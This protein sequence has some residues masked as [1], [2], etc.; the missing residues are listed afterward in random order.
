MSYI[1]ILHVG[2]VPSNSMWLAEVPKS[3]CKIHTQRLTWQSKITIFNGQID[4]I[5]LQMVDVPLIIL[6]FGGSTYLFW[7]AK[8]VARRS[9]CAIAQ[10]ISHYGGGHCWG[11]RWIHWDVLLD[12]SKWL[13]TLGNTVD[14]RNP[15]PPGMYKTL[16][17][18]FTIS[19][20]AGFLP[21]TVALI[22]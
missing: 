10:S 12:L 7:T 2:I 22:S 21:S 5:H 3:P 16:Y 14:G 20:G 19:T 13:G 1:Y 8:D 4:Q 6:V 18:I 15:A 9:A 17:R 11:G